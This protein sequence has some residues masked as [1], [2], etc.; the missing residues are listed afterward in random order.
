MRVLFWILGLGSLANGAWMLLAPASW[1]VGLPADVPDTGPFNEH[2]V[3]DI[4]AAFATLGLAFALAASRPA[5]Q[6][7]VLLAAS[8]FLGLHALIHVADLASGRLPASHWLTDL[9]GVFLP[10]ALVGVLSLPRF[11]RAGAR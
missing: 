2:F 4:G 10:A 9:P 11:W 5:H 3:R 8:A 6:R 1:Y 7:A